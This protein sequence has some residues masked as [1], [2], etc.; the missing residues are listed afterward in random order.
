MVDTTKNL[1][2]TRVFFI[3]NVGSS[4][5][6]RFVLSYPTPPIGVT[7]RGLLGIARIRPD[8]RKFVFVSF[9]DF[10]PDLTLEQKSGAIRCPILV[11]QSLMI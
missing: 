1:S 3:C 6:F 5:D 10:T 8:V 9:M 4:V 11:D 2:F 7:I